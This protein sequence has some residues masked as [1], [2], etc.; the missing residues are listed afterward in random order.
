MAPDRHAPV[1][2]ARFLYTPRRTVMLKN[3]LVVGTQRTGSTA[4]HRALN[5]HP[6]IACGNEWTHEVS[7]FSKFSVTERALRGDL[8]VLDERQRKRISQTLHP[9]TEWLGFKICSAR[10]T[11]GSFI[12]YAPA[13]WFDRLEATSAG[14]RAGVIRDHRRDPSSGSVKY[15]SDQH[16]MWTGNKYPEDAR[17]RCGGQGTASPCEQ[18][19]DRRTSVRAQRNQSVPRREL[20]GFPRFEP[21][22]GDGARHV[23]GLRSDRSRPS[24]TSSEASE[25]PRAHCISNF[26]G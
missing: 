23:P 26:D 15:L 21:R 20:R 18:A 8:D 6:A 2:R 12:R 9:G 13:L 16:R 11:S 5:F 24:T 3:F 22:D 7:P 19:L 10:Q 4:L 14:C 17:R 1:D 25:P